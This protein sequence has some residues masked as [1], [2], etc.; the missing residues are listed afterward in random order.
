M[1]ISWF[2]AGLGIFLVGVL[3]AIVLIGIPLII[4]GPGA[5]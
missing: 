2:L 4:L 5:G 1:S 3:L